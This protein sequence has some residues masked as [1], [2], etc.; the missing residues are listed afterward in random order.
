MLFVQ[1]GARKAAIESGKFWGV[2]QYNNNNNNNDDDD[3]DNNNRED[4]KYVICR[5]G[6]PHDEKL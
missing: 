5:L 4:N 3:N 6:G 2:L 1:T